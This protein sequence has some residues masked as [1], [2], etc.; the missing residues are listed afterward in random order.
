[1]FRLGQPENASALATF[2]ASASAPAKLRAEA[3][4]QLALWPKP[5]QRDRLVGI[6]RPLPQKTR[7]RA[8]A[9]K[10]LQPITAGLLA[11]ATPSAVQLELINTATTRSRKSAEI[12]KLL[13][14]H[15]A[16]IAASPDP[17]A[18]YRVTLAGGDKV[19]G[20]RI[21]RN[22]PTMA[23]IRC[24]RAGADGGDAGPN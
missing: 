3:I 14:R 19:R 24:H 10:A 17:L 23:C 11:P 9:V 1:H 12:K 20:E 4:A 13:D 16:A 18:P 7:D 15:D 5:P 8:V 21:F 6:Y 2:A 22:Q